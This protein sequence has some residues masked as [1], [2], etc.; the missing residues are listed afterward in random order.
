[1]LPLARSSSP[2]SR[3]T[4]ATV[5]YSRMALSSKLR[6]P[7]N[8]AR[9]PVSRTVSRLHSSALFVRTMSWSTSQRPPSANA[10]PETMETVG[11]W[12]PHEFDTDMAI[13]PTNAVAPIKNFVEAGASSLQDLGLGSYFTPV[14]WI[15]IAMDS[16]HSMG[17]PWWAAIVATTVCFRAVTVPL[18]LQTHRS[19]PQCMAVMM[20]V[21]DS[22]TRLRQAQI[23][24]DHEQIAKALQDFNGIM[25]REYP[26]AMLK[27]TLPSVAQAPIFISLFLALRSMAIAPVESLKT[28][29]FLW[30]PDLTIAD[31]YYLLPLMTCATLAA[32]IEIG[33]ETPVRV[34]QFNAM[35]VLR[36]L[37]VIFFP[38]IMKYPAAVLC[39][40][41]TNNFVSLG[42]AYTL[43]IPAIRKKY[44]LPPLSEMR[45]GNDNASEKRN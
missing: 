30:F 7:K 41:A 32:I 2:I 6:Q 29:G 43:K 4:T 14:G 24:A 26:R 39:F 21:R 31:P 8:V 3:L 35:K 36:F 42:L 25:A 37:P 33:A 17:L 34:D 1:M 27:Q 38:L 28:G 12:G 18:L 15:Q 22:A 16:M 13:D 5:A 9:L 40:W 19:T 23:G 10:S 20:R 11:S 44:N 45:I